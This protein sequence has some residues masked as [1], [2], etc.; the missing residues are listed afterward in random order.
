MKNQELHCGSDLCY[1]TFGSN[2]IKRH[3]EFKTLFAVQDPMLN[4]PPRTSAPNNKVD[5]LFS[6]LLKV[7]T[8]A[9]E[10]GEHLSSDEQDSSF[11]GRHEDKARVTFK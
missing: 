3:K 1:A 8:D 2:A 4:I 6:H 5:H 10:P 11:Q 9:Y 7:S